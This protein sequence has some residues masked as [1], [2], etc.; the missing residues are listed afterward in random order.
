MRCPKCGY[1]SFDQQPSCEK[2]SADLAE[3]AAA[4]AGTGLKAQETFFLA[5]VIGGADEGED[6]EFD[7]SEMTVDDE[8]EFGG[9]E[10]E[11]GEAVPIVNLAAFGAGGEDEELSLTLAGEEEDEAETAA[12]EDVLGGQEEAVP[13][14]IDFPMSEEEMA[15]V[16]VDLLLDRQKAP[17][18][19]GVESELPSGEELQGDIEFQLEEAPDEISLE[20]EDAV[21]GEQ[22]LEEAEEKDDGMDFDLGL[23]PDI[24]MDDETPEQAEAEALSGGKSDSGLKLDLDVDLEDEP[25]ENEMVFNLEDIDMDDLLITENGGGKKGRPEDTAVD[26]EDFLN[27]GKGADEQDDPDGKSSRLPDI[28]L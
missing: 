5:S 11:E 22:G 20:E 7:L 26:L 28:D 24:D 23:M 12:E 6:R 14:S 2:C 9:V 15:G 21:R 16:N 19:K 1:I 8:V 17:A 18:T 25:E 27:E 3:I 4:L 10:S 13:G